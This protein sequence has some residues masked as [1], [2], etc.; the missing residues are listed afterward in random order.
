MKLTH[1]EISTLN[2]TPITKLALQLWPDSNFVALFDDFSE[3]IGSPNHLVMLVKLQEKP[4][5]FAHV[6]LRNEYVEGAERFPVAYLEGIYVTP[7]HQQKGIGEY[8][9]EQAQ[10]WAQAQGCTQLASDVELPNTGSQAFHQKMGFVEANRVV[11]Y[12]KNLT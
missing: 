2:V 6:A 1:E 10:I 7:D 8:M 11:C 3:M 4:V 5:G 9:L 12:I